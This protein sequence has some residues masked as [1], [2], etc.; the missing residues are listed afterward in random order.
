MIGIIAVIASL[1]A[2]N[3]EL[4]KKMD[5][6]GYTSLGHKGEYF[7][8]GRTIFK[9]K[10]ASILNSGKISSFTKGTLEEVQKEILA[11][12]EDTKQYFIRASKEDKVA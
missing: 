1:N 5:E 11:D 7:V 6:L 9:V 2:K 3:E 4:V 8:R 12:I 10:F